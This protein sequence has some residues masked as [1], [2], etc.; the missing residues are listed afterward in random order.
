MCIPYV[1]A[2]DDFD[3]Q[4]NVASVARCVVLANVTTDLIIHAD[5]AD[6]RNVGTFLIN[7]ALLNEGPMPVPESVI[8]ALGSESVALEALER[9]IQGP[10]F[11]EESKEILLLIIERRQRAD[12]DRNIPRSIIF[13]GLRKYRKLMKSASDNGEIDPTFCSVLNRISYFYRKQGSH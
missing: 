12:E 8:G 6:V 10:Q 13:K 1:A 7:S 5:R 9:A 3:S 4:K 2:F 11:P